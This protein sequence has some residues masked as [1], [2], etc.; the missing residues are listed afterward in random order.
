MAAV[1]LWMSGDLA[2]W[3]GWTRSQRIWRLGG[4]IALGGLS[5][6]AALSVA[7]VRLSAFWP[8]GGESVE[9]AGRLP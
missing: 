9:S 3:L 8:S 1:L 2:S 7:G 5:Y 6:F 4:T